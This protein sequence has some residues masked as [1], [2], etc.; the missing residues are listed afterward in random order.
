METGAGKTRVAIAI[1]DLLIRCNWVK[2]VL[3]LADRCALVLQAVGAFKKFLP[4]ANPLNLL[5]DKQARESR[6]VVSTYHTIMNLLEQE[7][8]QGQMLFSPGHFDLIVID[9]AHRSV[10]QKFGAIF[11]YFDSL[12]LGLTATP[13]NEIDRNT[14]RL[15]ELDR[16]L[17]TYS[18]DLDTAIADGYLVPPK[19]ISVPLKFQREGISYAELSEQEKEQWDLLEWEDDRPPD[20]VEADA[21]NSWLFNEDTVDKVLEHLMQHGLKVKGGDRLGKTII[22]A[23]NHKHAQFIEQRFN[24]HYPHLAGHFARIIDHYDPRAHELLIDFSQPEKAPHIA[25]SVDML[26][27]GVDIEEVLNLVFFKPVRSKTKFIQMIGRG[28][29][30]CLHLF[31]P[32][33]DKVEFYIFDQRVEQFVRE[34]QDF[35]VIH[36]NQTCRSADRN[37]SGAA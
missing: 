1:C 26:D 15:F 34:H 19:A 30:L 7:N 16:G 4:S 3:F 27:T 33:Q 36:K 32:G 23:K 10:Y 25:I 2:K 18:Y 17:P 37:R 8:A 31:G 20:A 6:V 28:T 21:L 35:I 24:T 11:R 5:D 9:E 12:L 14:Y 13:K 22:F 29:R